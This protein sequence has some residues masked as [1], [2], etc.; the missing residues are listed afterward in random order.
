MPAAVVAVECPRM[1]LARLVCLLAVE[2]VAVGCRSA[3][4]GTVALLTDYG[5]KDHYVG[6]LSAAVLAANPQ[7]RLVPITHEIEPYNIAQGAFVLAEA[8]SEFPAGTVVVAV[9][10]P[11]VGTAR[12]PIVVQTRRGLLLVG[13]DNGLLDPLICR[14]GGARGVWRIE[15][16]RLVRAGAASS[17]FHGRD[18]FGPVAGHLSRGVRPETVGP[19]LATWVHLKLPEPTHDERGL[20]GAV[21][22]V[23]RYGNLL[24]NIPAAWLGL[25]P[26][27]GRLVVRCRGRTLAA[28]AG[29]TYADVAPGEWVVLANASRYV[30]IARNQASAAELLGCR[31]GEPVE[32]APPG[33]AADAAGGAPQ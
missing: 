16:P 17:T 22:H 5:A 25:M 31:A 14:D 1:H 33:A 13:P 32:I 26:P 15:N 21:V 11:G 3:A 27:D 10:D 24:T 9:V 23:D 2:L 19:P 4:T 28:R 18:L 7:A 20:C 30:E 8:G 29:R 6:V 12:A